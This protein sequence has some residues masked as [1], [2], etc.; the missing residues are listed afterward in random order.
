MH[1]QWETS[2]CACHVLSSATYGKCFIKCQRFQVFPNAGE[3]SL[4]CRSLEEQQLAAQHGGKPCGPFSEAASVAL[5]TTY[6]D[7]PR[8][9]RARGRP[10]KRTSS[11]LPVCMLVLLSREEAYCICTI[12]IACWLFPLFCGLFRLCLLS[13]KTDHSIWNRIKMPQ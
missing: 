7:S 13:L 4:N 9:V 3:M 8:K 2:V 1:N 6:V 11:W 10:P 12:C 5:T